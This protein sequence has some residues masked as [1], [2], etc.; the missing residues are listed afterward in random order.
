MES[1]TFF[2]RDYTGSI[3]YHQRWTRWWDRM[4]RDDVQ[5]YTGGLNTDTMYGHYR[6]RKLGSVQICLTQW[7]AQLK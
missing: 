5:V 6:R 7:T 2:R 4:H 1:S 3:F